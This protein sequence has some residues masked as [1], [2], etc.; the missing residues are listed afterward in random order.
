MGI[1]A[2]G[3]ATASALRTVGLEPTVI[4]EQGGTQLAQRLGCKRGASVL[5]PCAEETS[6]DLERELLSFG[7]RVERVPIYRSVRRAQAALV[8]GA[9]V[10]I[11]F[12]PSSVRAAAA[13]AHAAN[14]TRLI[15]LGQRTAQACQLLGWPA[16][17]AGDTHTESVVAEVAR[18]I[19]DLEV[20]T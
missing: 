15:A 3:E 5:F 19:H 4:G 10:R 1:A 7:V 8:Q 13:L 17:V 14:S 11:F 6:G 2:V 18:A 16:R 12:S 9:D 20:R